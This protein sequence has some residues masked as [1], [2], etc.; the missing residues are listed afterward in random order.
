MVFD[1]RGVPVNL[2]LAGEAIH[3]AIDSGILQGP[4]GPTGPAGADGSPGPPGATG[5]AGA[6]AVLMFG[7]G[8]WGAGTATKYAD[9]WWAPTAAV[10]TAVKIP[11]P[12]DGTLRN[13]RLWARIGGT[14]SFT[15][16]VRVNDVVTALAVLVGPLVTT[17]ANLINTVAVTAGALVDLEI[18]RT[19]AGSPTDIT[20]TMELA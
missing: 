14:G 6:G 11:V 15:A 19:L 7:N 16:Q 20:I 17:A 10:T 3:I 4:A 1:D 2:N 13:L 5:P 18:V 12:R 9:P 8:S